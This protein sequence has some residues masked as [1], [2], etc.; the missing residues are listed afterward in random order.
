[1]PYSDMPEQAAII[2][3]SGSKLVL[4]VFAGTGKTSQMVRFALAK[5]GNRMLYVAGG[6]AC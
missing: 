2:G 1:M 4:K 3:W 6:V 5:P